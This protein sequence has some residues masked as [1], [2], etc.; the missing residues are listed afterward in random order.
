MG[1]AR[2]ELG[3]SKD[4]GVR[5]WVWVKLGSC[6]DQVG[7][8]LGQDSGWGQDFLWLVILGIR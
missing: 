7:L 3:S 8:D 2:I 1:H 6:W 4:C 5:T